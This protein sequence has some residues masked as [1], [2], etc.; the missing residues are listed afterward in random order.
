MGTSQVREATHK[1][2]GR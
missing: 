1:E 2:V